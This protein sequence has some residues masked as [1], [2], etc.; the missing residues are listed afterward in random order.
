MT[1]VLILLYLAAIVAANLAVAAFGPAVTIVNA[2]VLIAFDLTA[3]DVLHDR[4]QGRGLWL[5]MAL[6]IGTGGAISYALNAD[7]GSIAVASFVAFSVAGVLDGLTYQLLG[8]R[9][10]LLRMNGSNVVGAAADSLIF[11]T[12][13]F[14]A[15]LPAIVIGQFAAKVAGG[16]LW[17]L[18][19]NAVSVRR[20]TV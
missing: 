2:F 17:S 4:W 14:G 13:A 18:V 10:R 19:L 7:A 9:T 8:D 16:F 5:R 20:N 12:L 11:P 15:L 1:S 3:R 6:L